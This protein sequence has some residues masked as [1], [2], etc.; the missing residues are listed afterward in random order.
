MGVET[1][2]GTTI[3]ICAT[4]P[5]TYD[6][7][8]YG[9]LPFIEAGEVTDLGSFG[10]V[11]ALVTHQ[12]IKTR[13]TK[14]LKGSFNEGTIQLTYGYDASDAGQVIME[15]AVNSDAAYAIRIVSQS[16]KVFYF[17]AL[18]MSAPKAFGGVDNVVS[19]TAQLELTTSDSGVGIVVV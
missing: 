1:T 2:A 15:Q 5:A 19:V 12:P 10:R 7:A 11:Y 16:G 9:V 6:A 14:K 17:L 3:S 13:G 8:G 18:V 4:L